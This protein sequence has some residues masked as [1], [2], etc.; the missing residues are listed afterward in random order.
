M[1][2]RDRV[3]IGA[4]VE[5]TDLKDGGKSE[6]KSDEFGEFWVTGLKLNNDYSI[7]ISRAGYKD[8]TATI[9]LDGDKDIGVIDLP[10]S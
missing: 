10:N 9:F 8:F 5:V 6:T 1:C 4:S 2:I 3:I 7:K